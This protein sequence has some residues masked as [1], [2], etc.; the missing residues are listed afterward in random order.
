MSI[1]FF[2]LAMRRVRVLAEAGALV[3]T[4]CHLHGIIIVQR[5]RRWQP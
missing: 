4:L 1:L 2:S 3:E 5:R